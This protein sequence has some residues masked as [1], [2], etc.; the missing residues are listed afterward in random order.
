MQVGISLGLGANFQSYPRP[1]GLNSYFLPN[2]DTKVKLVMMP[3][4]IFP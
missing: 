1:V 3:S 4:L 2:L